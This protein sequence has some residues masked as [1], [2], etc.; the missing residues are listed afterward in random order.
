MSSR[1]VYLTADERTAAP[2]IHAILAK[3]RDAVLSGSSVSA[4]ISQAKVSLQSIAGLELQ[5]LELC[6][7]DTLK[8]LDQVRK[9]FVVLVAA[10][11]GNVRLIDNVVES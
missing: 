3:V 9:P 6:D 5:Y 8:P 11:L 10:K 2:G 7:A 4:A 1:N